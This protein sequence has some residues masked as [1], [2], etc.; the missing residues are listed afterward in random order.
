MILRNFVT[1]RKRVK[2]S[3]WNDEW[4]WKGRT[5]GLDGSETDYRWCTCASQLLFSPVYNLCTLGVASVDTYTKP[6]SNIYQ[7]GTALVIVMEYLV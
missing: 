1:K 7:R 4:N 5:L 3:G 2:V 6:R